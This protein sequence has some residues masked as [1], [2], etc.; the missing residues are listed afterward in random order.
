[1]QAVALTD[2]GN[3]FGAVKHWKVQ[4]R[5][6]STDRGLR[7]QRRADGRHPRRPPRAPSRRRPRAT[8][9]RSSS[10]RSASPATHLS[11]CPTVT[12]ADVAEQAKG[13]VALTGCLGGM[14]PQ[15]ICQHGADSGEKVLG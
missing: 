13:L 12:L 15:A 10:S 11:Q 3:M 7:A 2:L 9:T 6:G 14:A 5:R 1:M 8:R 4:G